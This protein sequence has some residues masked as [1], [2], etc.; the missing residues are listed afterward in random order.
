MAQAAIPDE[1]EPL[2]YISEAGA[3]MGNTALTPGDAAAFASRVDG[4]VAVVTYWHLS[5]PSGAWPDANLWDRVRTV[6]S[7]VVAALK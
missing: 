3:G 6:F 2:F 7:A 1:D 5:V 4:D